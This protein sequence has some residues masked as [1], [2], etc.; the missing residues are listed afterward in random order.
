MT[1]NKL[2][3]LATQRIDRFAHEQ[4]NPI[5]PL[6][7]AEKDDCK[8]L[9]R[10]VKGAVGIITRGLAWI[11]SDI[12]DAGPDLLFISR[13]GHGY[14]NVDIDA[15]TA[16]GIPVIYAPL[17]GYAV[18]EGTM[19]ILLALTKRLFYFHDAVVAGNWNV[20]VT[21]RTEDLSGRRM[22]I[23]GLG[24]IGQEVAK[25]A[26]PFEME[27]VAHDPYIP[28]E[29]AQDLNVTLLSLDELLGTSDVITIHAV[30]TSETDALINR[31]NLDKV[32]RGAYFMNFAR[33]Q[34]VEDLD[35]LHEALED[36]RLAGVGLDVFPEEP[37]SN[38]DHPLF[39]HPNFVCS[40]HVIGST[41]GAERRCYQ[42]ICKD[43]KKVLNG[44]QPEWCV[45][46]EVFDSPNLRK[47]GDS[48][49]G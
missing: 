49:V 43:V 44:E 27:L 24:R 7:E 30:S 25:R 48:D 1:S 5:Y 12:M 19:A 16:R 13:T 47:P 9:T 32:K 4:L 17:L 23:V 42:S 34:L 11:G 22:G 18:A 15:A 41:R 36:G 2:H 37:P 8:T 3:F 14:E 39:K 10:M 6:I 45:N 35:I 40:P 21:E 29:I 38:I 46:P 31:S 28:K 33:G 20:R 26:A